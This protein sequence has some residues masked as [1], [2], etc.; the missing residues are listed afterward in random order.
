[1]IDVSLEGHG[2][3]TGFPRSPVVEC[4]LEG[5]SEQRMYVVQEHHASHLHWD[6]RLEMNGAL[7]SWAVPMKPPEVVG[8]RRLAVEVED[9]PMEYAFFEGKIPEGEYGAGVVKIWDRGTYD[10]VKVTENKIV[11]TIHG[12]RLKGNYCLL[13]TRFG[14]AAKN[15][16]FFK[17]K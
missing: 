11:L 1:V 7:R 12:E 16:L 6:L 9:H 15:W 4:E 3:K 13:R 2:G 14:G 17:M 10:A 8:V 5:V